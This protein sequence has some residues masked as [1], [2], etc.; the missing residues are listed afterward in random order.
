MTL[1]KCSPNTRGVHHTGRGT[2]MSGTTAKVDVLVRQARERGI[3]TIGVG[4]L[5]NEI[6]FGNIRET[7]ERYIPLV[8][9]CGCGGSGA[10]ATETDY[11]VVASSS[12]R[13]GYG[14]E[15]ALAALLG[16]VSL[17]HSG[18]MDKQMILAA[19]DHGAI[20]SFTV[21]PTATDGH[22][23]D[24]HYSACLVELL[25]QIVQSRDVEFGMYAAR[26]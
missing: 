12:N 7:V 24:M 4:D 14:V 20:D 8:C 22:G 13:G 2:N 17:V 9:R 15:A 6:G 1:E 3:L 5:G 11:L 18:E 23:V 26:S 21:A 16:D 25:R 10:A 19:R